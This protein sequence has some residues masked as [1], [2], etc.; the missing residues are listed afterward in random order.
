MARNDGDSDR[1]P[2]GFVRGPATFPVRRPEGTIYVTVPGNWPPSIRRNGKRYY[3]TGKLGHRRSDQAQAA[4]Y[5]AVDG[6]GRRTGE[7]VWLLDDGTMT[8]E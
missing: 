3:Q 1:P 4:E 6:Q 2:N 5:E 7:R 8:E